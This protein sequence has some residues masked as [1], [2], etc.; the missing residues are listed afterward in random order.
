MLEKLRVVSCEERIAG[1]FEAFCLFDGE[2]NTF[3]V[4]FLIDTVRQWI[5]MEGLAMAVRAPDGRVG[6]EPVAA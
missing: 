6:W 1:V 2:W 3:A 4:T 5:E